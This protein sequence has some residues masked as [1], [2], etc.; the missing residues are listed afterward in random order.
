L[1]D[2][3][4]PTNTEVDAPQPEESSG[5][6]ALDKQLASGVLQGD[7]GTEAAQVWIGAFVI[8]A[9]GFIVY[10]YA[11]NIP[12][13]GDDLTLLGG[14]TSVSRTVTALE[15][16]PQMAT[17]PLAL[18]GLS[19]NSIFGAEVDL[20]HGG[21]ILLHLLCAI[22]VFLIARRLLPPKT[23]EAIA[24]LAGILFVVHP[25]TTEPVNYLVARSVLQSSFFGLTA[26]LLLL[27]GCT[28]KRHSTASIVASFVFLALA[29]GS[30]STALCFPLIGIALVYYRGDSGTGTNDFRGVVAG[31]LLL[32]TAIMWI[33]GHASGLLE[34][35]ASERSF[36]LAL[37]GF[38]SQA[39]AG[40][41]YG[42][43]P[44]N[45]EILPDQG[46]ALLGIIATILIAGGIALGLFWQRLGAV[47]GLWVLLALLGAALFGPLGD[48]G[49]TRYLYLPWAAICILA[50]LGLQALNNPRSRLIAGSLAAVLTLAL[51]A[52]S[53]QRCSLWTRPAD[54]WAN[55]RADKPESIQPSLAI[56]R[57]LVHSLDSGSEFDG[58]QG[59]QVAQAVAAWKDVTEQDPESAEAHEN[60]GVLAIA[61]DQ[62]SD[63]ITHLRI[64]TARNPL[65]Q[66]P[67][68]SLAIAAEQ[69]ARATGD[70]TL[71]IESLR[72]LERINRKGK[73][74]LPALERYSQLAAQIGDTMTALTLMEMVAEEGREEAL[75]VPLERL[76]NLSQQIN[77]LGEQAS[78]AQREAPRSAEGL[79]LQAQRN[80]LQGQILSAF[81]VLQL[82]ATREP[83]NIGAWTLLGITSARLNGT[84]NFLAERGSIPGADIDAWR[85]L[86]FRCA[87][88]GAWPAAEIYLRHGTGQQS[89]AV[90][91]PEL[92]LADVATELKQPQRALAYAEA[93]RKA[94]PTNALP[95]LRLVDLAI[96]SDDKGRARALLSEAEKL[97]AD[98]AA[99]QERL[100]KIG[101]VSPVREGITRTIIK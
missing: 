20:L 90:A 97:N 98:S 87:A 12:L 94:H 74:P 10:L 77:A 2:E 81:Y 65:D 46:S 29:F 36:T 6:A 67:A 31:A 52:I 18:L 15:S 26:L 95:V 8:T 80:L 51:A 47:V 69:Q 48:V 91:L 14:E 17:A 34:A 71:L 28:P 3:K 55:A 4:D 50:P 76:R 49:P 93:A 32:A 44:L 64:A 39:G 72:A 24:M 35:T 53:F 5:N 38:L 23:P 54:L 7:V 100:D 70:T 9:L 40:I 45:Y 83:S 66:K 16:L 89:D 19:V 88:A 33:A 62:F 78:R 25:L 92:I 37:K 68:L 82:A 99:I 96:A 75:A 101:N 61:Q 27:R 56:G 30:D 11:F 43:L 21:S 73:L 84:Q 60:L 22:L 85:Q 41:S 1:N 57:Y 63:A 58:Q 13:H 42:L 59:T 86:A 79:V